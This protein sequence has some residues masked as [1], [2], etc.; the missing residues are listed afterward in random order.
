MKKKLV[1]LGLAFVTA[2]TMTALGG[3]TFVMAESEADTPGVITMEKS[4]AEWITQED[5]DALANDQQ[6][7]VGFTD[8]FDGNT[9]HQQQERY[10]NDLASAM[11]DAGIIKDYTM[12]VANNDVATQVQ[13][14]ESFIMQGCNLI[15]IDPC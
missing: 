10:F 13:Q 15:V 6:Y 1:A 11:K 12:V 5:M 9:L 14:I 2:T 3:T 4:D 8:N 7:V